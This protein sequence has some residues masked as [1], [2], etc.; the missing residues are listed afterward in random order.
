MSRQAPDFVTDWCNP[1][2]HYTKP[3]LATEEAF[4]QVQILLDQSRKEERLAEIN[5]L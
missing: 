2:V 3:Q 4:R 1:D 5:N